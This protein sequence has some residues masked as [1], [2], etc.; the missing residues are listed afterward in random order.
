[1]G[2]SRSVIFMAAPGGRIVESIVQASNGEP[3]RRSNPARAAG[4]R[5]R[6]R[7]GRIAGA[8]DRPRSSA[9]AGAHKPADIARRSIR[10]TAPLAETGGSSTL[11]ACCTST[12]SNSYSF[13]D[14]LTSRSPTLTMRRTRSTER[15][16]ARNTGRSP[17]D[18]QL[19]PQRRAHA[20]EQFIHPER[21][22]QIVVGA[23][24]E[25]LD[26][27]GL[28]AAARQHHDRDAVVAAADHAQQFM[29]LD[30]RQ[31][32]IENDQAR[33]PAPAIRARS[34]R[35]RLPGSRSPACSIPSAAICGS[36]AHRR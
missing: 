25:R 18:L 13:G 35:W 27:A 28:V 36:A 11:P 14:S 24:I 22:C 34:C 4:S 26:L 30:I 12:R 5:C 2:D 15:S 29:A 9:G 8:P 17:C 19:M 6:F 21:F 1:M 3:V 31:A 23:E 33:D 10:P 20:G 7:S 16:P 32:E